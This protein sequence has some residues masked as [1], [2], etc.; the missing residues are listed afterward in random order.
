MLF[1]SFFTVALL[2][3]IYVWR[4]CFLTPLMMEENGERKR[5]PIEREEA[6][7]EA[8]HPKAVDE[9]GI[10]SSV[11]L[12]LLRFCRNDEVLCGVIAE[13]ALKM[14]ALH[15]AA[16]QLINLHMRLVYEHA[17]ER[18]VLPEER[19]WTPDR[20][21]QYFYAV[22]DLPNTHWQMP[23]EPF[24][25]LACEKFK[26]IAP[27]ISREGVAA[28]NFIGEAAKRLAASINTQVREHFVQ[29]QLR[30]F[31]LRAAVKVHKVSD[32]ER[33]EMVSVEEG[34]ALQFAVNTSGEND[35]SLPPLPGGMSVLTA[36][37]QY[38]EWFL[39]HIHRMNR[40]FEQHDHKKYAV[41]PLSTGFVPGAYLHVDTPSLYA[42]LKDPRLAHLQK[43]VRRYEAAVGATATGSK[44]RPQPQAFGIVNPFANQTVAQEGRI[45]ADTQFVERD[46]EGRLRYKN[47]EALNVSAEDDIQRQELLQKQTNLIL[48]QIRLIERQLKHFQ[49]IP[50]LGALCERL[51]LH[52]RVLRGFQPPSQYVSR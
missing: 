39:F 45:V 41:F 27:T 51:Q 1:L 26:L 49:T 33:P 25:A 42:L 47:V 8:E 38:P 18:Q 12:S 31:R 11:K 21:R 35:E 14:R 28:G 5:K 19:P 9:F 48:D 6:S 37:E 50:Q 15:V 30:Y 43:H 16:L 17:E 29:I 4:L 2:L 46:F 36:L 23:D 24:F 44:P 13:L 3:F 40:L 22:S 34:R 20:V 32:K 10:I 7:K 52:C